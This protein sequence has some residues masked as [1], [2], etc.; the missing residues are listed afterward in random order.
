[1]LRTHYDRNAVYFLR[2]QIL[3]FFYLHITRLFVFLAYRNRVVCF[4]S[5]FT[6]SKL[7]TLGPD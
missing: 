6:L 1:M 4:F 7:F 5:T 2:T 3:F